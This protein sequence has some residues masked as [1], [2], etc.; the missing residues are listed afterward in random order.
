M[1][2]NRALAHHQLDDYVKAAEDASYVLEHFDGKNLKAL[3][4]RA[5]ANRNLFNFRE[6]VVDLNKL[7]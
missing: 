4:R 7:K 5:S 1:Y 2:T 3:M 6:A